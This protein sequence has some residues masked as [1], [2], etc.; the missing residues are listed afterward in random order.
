MS[1]ALLLIA[2][3]AVGALLLGIVARRGHDMGL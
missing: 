2:L 1:P 3:A